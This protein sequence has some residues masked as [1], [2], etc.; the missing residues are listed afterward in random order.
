MFFLQQ[1]LCVQLDINH[2]MVVCCKLEVVVAYRDA[3]PMIAKSFILCKAKKQIETVQLFPPHSNIASEREKQ[4]MSKPNMV[5]SKCKFIVEWEKNR[6]GES[7]LEE[8]T[9]WIYFQL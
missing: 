5:P 8:K 1:D 2:F 3:K 6:M 7:E 4:T 9:D